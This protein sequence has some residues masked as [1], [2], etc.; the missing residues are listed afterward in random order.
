SSA[1]WSGTPSLTT[2][3]Y[4]ARNC[5]PSLYWISALSRPFF[6]F[7]LSALMLMDVSGG[8]LIFSFISLVPRCKHPCGGIA[9]SLVGTM[10]G[11]YK[12]FLLWNFLFRVGV[13][14]LHWY[15]GHHPI[16]LGASGYGGK[17]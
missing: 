12:W 16:R 4:I 15:R 17:E 6:R 5:W 1:N 9:A 10:H 7:I 8:C 13:T 3:V 11:Q 14:S 2:S